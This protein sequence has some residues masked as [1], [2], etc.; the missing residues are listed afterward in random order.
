MASKKTIP[1]GHQW[2]DSDDIKE[3]VKV[4]KGD[5]LTQ[6]PKVEEF[7]KA[8][9]KYCKVKYAVAFSSG[10][11][12]LHGAYMATGIGKGDEVITTPLTF[13]ATSN[14]LYFCGAKPVFADIER[15]TLN[16][17]HLLVEGLITK[18]TKAIVTVDFAGN[19]CNYD[20]ILSLAKK[21]KLL[22]IEDA[23]H[24]LGAK[25]KGKKVGSFADM[26]VFSFHPVKHITTGEGGMVLTDNEDFFKKLK[27]LRSHGIVK[28]PE[29][30]GWYYQIEN[31]SFNYR[32]TDIQ[33]ALGLSQLKKLDKFI[34]R[35]REIVEIYHKSFKDIKNLILP[36]ESAGSFSAWHIY[37]VQIIGKERREFFEQLKKNG[38]G[39]QVHYMPL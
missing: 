30:G 1:Y 2:L 35:R 14:I 7:E 39:V 9:A 11:S 23:C 15:D 26:T 3:V 38:I 36:K 31:P 25:Y 20:E 19:P 37:P 24:A 4:L 29:K 22:V 6:G 21:H 16:I 17:N 5:W 34:M 33:S 10:T 8:V 12:A 27:V 28:Q 13:A 32:L 18:K